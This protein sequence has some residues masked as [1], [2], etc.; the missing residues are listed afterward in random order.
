MTTST[1]P[2]RFTG[3]E[4]DTD[5]EIPAARE[6]T[7]EHEYDGI[8]EY[9]NPLP[10]WWVL[11]FWGTFLFSLGYVFHYHVSGRGPSVAQ[12]YELEMAA[13]REQRAARSLGEKVTEE[14]LR[15]LMLDAELMADAKTLFG[16]RCASCHGDR[17]QGL[18]GPNL[19][20]D[21]WIHGK[22]TLMDIHDIVS[23]GVPEK[24]M[25]PW[26][27]QLTPIELRKIAALV[28][29]FK[30]QNLPGKPPQGELAQAQ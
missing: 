28:G 12:S 23:R 15:T 13:A 9:D 19:T 10:R 30:G 20:D 24:G 4:T 7:L 16:A 29:S 2:E 5:P 11:L 27:A 3:T 25:P 26:E 1:H 21:Y 8:R 22:G 6:Q 14:A 18:I 17:G